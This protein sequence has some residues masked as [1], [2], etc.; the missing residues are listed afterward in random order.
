MKTT[1]VVPDGDGGWNVKQGGAERSSAKFPTKQ[2]AIN[3][4][5]EISRN[6]GSELFIHNKNGRIGSKD[7]HG[8]DPFP[9]I[10]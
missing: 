3:R 5:R 6:L 9:P 4:A 2:P 10:G 8:K 7:S 1:H